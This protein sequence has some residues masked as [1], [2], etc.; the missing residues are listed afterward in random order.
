MAFC[1][2]AVCRSSSTGIPLSRGKERPHC[3]QLRAEGAETI[4]PP[5]AGHCRYPVDAGFTSDLESCAALS[6]SNR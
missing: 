6:S 1:S 5:Q 3:V 4:L 2:T